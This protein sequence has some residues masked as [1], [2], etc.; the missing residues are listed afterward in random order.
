MAR[1][2]WLV[3]ALIGSV[4]VNLALVGFVV[5]VAASDVRMP[6]RGMGFDATA[7][8]VH[9][10]RFLPEDRRA[11]VLQGA[12]AE[13]PS[14]QSLRA[15]RRAQHEIQAAI[16]AEPF[17]P[18]ALTAALSTFSERFSESQQ[19]SHAV[20]VLMMAQ[21]TPEERQRFADTMRHMREPRPGRREGRGRE[22][23][24]RRPPDQRAESPPSD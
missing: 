8:L 3:V 9:L 19:R 14:R 6:W 23:G 15:M 5:G 10:I 20:L 13:R 17:D 1:N 11:E 4:A 24:P 22:H 16:A 2:R 21:L 12:G 18:V 7:G